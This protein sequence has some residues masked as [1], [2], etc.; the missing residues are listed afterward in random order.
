MLQG[1]LKIRKF[2]K[3]HSKQLRN[4]EE[5]P[6]TLFIASQH[7]PR[8]K[9][10]QGF[11]HTIPNDLAHNRNN[12]TLDKVFVDASLKDEHNKIKKELET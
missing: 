3:R 2:S 9:L 4:F 6:A 1:Q 7:T 10:K 8:K 5:S 12:S 11:G